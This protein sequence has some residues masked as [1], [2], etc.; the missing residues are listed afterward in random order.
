MKLIP[1]VI[2]SE[3]CTRDWSR[4]L[5]LQRGIRQVYMSKTLFWDGKLCENFC[6]Q[7]THSERTFRNIDIKTCVCISN[8]HVYS[9]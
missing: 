6:L 5:Y 4:G 8:L 3:F 9:V 2:P 1:C 7:A